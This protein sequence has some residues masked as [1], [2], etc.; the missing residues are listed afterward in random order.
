[1]RSFRTVNDAKYAS[2]IYLVDAMVHSGIRSL[3]VA[4]SNQRASLQGVTTIIAVLQTRKQHLFGIPAFEIASTQLC[5]LLILLWVMGG[6][7]QVLTE[8][9]AW[10]GRGLAVR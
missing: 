4:L 2:V 10:P 1:M 7:L 6:H 5:S 3:S 8:L 9:L